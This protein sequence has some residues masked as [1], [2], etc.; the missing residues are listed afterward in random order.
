MDFVTS[1]TRENIVIRYFSDLWGPYIFEME[2]S[3]PTD[4]TISAVTVKAYSGKARPKDSLD[5]FTEITNDL[6]DPSYT[7]NVQGSTDVYVKFQWP[8]D[9]YKGTKATLVF[10]ITCASGAKT[11]LYFYAVEIE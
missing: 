2:D 7:P 11:P 5:D 9:T 10:E 1:D 4:D 8:G 3:L 6:I